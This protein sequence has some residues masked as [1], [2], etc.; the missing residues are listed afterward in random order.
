MTESIADSRLEAQL[1]AARTPPHSI[2]AEQAVLG[3]LM[4]TERSGR[5]ETAWD[6]IAGRVGEVDFYIASHRSIFRG[7]HFLLE[8]DQRPDLVTLNDWLDKNE[9]LEDAG[10]L[11]Y[12]AA[13]EQ[14]TPSAANIVAYAD[15]VRD[16]SVLRQLIGVSNEIA[17]AAYRPEGK[18]NKELLDFAESK[19]FAIAEQNSQNSAGFK[20][21]RPILATTIDRIDTLFNSDGGLTG[22]STGFDNLDEKTSGLQPSDLIVIA[23]RPSMGKTSFAMNIAENV[24]MSADG[25]VAIFSM[26]M[27]AEQLA[28]R[29]LSSLG[30]V[31][32]QKIR[33][34]DLGESDWPR[35]TS[36]I[37]LLDQKRNIFIDDTPG[38]TPTELRARARRLA[39]EESGLSLL[40]VDYLQ[41][42]QVAGRSENRTAE[43]SEISRSLKSIA[44]ELNVPVVALSQLNRSLE[45]RPD[46]RPVMSDLRESGA[47]EQDAD[48]IM[49]IYR[50][51][52][53]NPE[54]EHKGKAE[55]LIRKQR[56]GPTGKIDLTFLGQFTK[57]ENY[58]PEIYSGGD[59]F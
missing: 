52:V 51:D 20:N 37:S 49:F 31:E 30:R 11:H 1:K 41:L 38:L 14:E 15:I 47:I 29:M 44:K 26:E 34:G 33:T 43:I 2:E 58:M 48:V 55:I 53:Y 56:N 39:R 45:Q 9:L 13:L 57:F 16:R 54:S 7:I 4:L 18:S 32:L 35:I 25:A 36:A 59:G 27:P 3:G 24:A 40:V 42:M 8:N 6:K 23:G 21:I 5:S 28:M 17:D 22:V 19:V 46:K 12:L 50:D 10:G